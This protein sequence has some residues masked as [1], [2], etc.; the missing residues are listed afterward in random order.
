MIKYPPYEGTPHEDRLAQMDE[1]LAAIGDDTTVLV[2]A[3]TPDEY[4]KG[5]IPGAVNV[6]YPR[7]AA[8]NPPNRYEPAERL[9]AMY[10]EMGVTPDRSVIPYCSSGVRS[11]VTAFSLW[12]I[13]FERVA[14]YTG[15][16][17][18]WGANPDTPKTEG[19][20]P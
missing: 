9:L 15:S 13:G 19:D 20:Q 10:R 6:N 12:L 11:A 17:Q 18:E 16:W 5:H 14:L 2:D 7:N 1:V 3:R 4:A 8:A